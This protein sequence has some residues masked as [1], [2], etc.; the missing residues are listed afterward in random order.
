ML[1]G[2]VLSRLPESYGGAARPVG[3]SAP[4]PRS[5]PCSVT[6][7][8]ASP[9]PSVACALPIRSSFVDVLR[10][11]H[12]PAR[13]GPRLRRGHSQERTP[14]PRPGHPPPN[15]R[16][17]PDR[18][19]AGARQLQRIP[20][21]P[22]RVVSPVGWRA[23]LIRVPLIVAA[24]GESDRLLRGGGGGISRPPATSSRS[25]SPRPTRS[26]CTAGRSGRRSSRTCSAPCAK[27]LTNPSSSRCRR[28]SVAPTRR[29]RFLPRSTRGVTIVNCGNTRRVD[30]PRLSFKT[31]GL[32]GPAL[33]T[34]TLA[35]V[36]R[37]RERFADRVEII[38]TGGIDTPTRSCRC[39]ARGP[40]PART[41]PPSYARPIPRAEN[42][43]APSIRKSNPTGYPLIHR[44][45][46]HEKK[47]ALMRFAGTYS[48]I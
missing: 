41:S 19:G 45:P 46:H 37:L 12:S 9:S 42:F 22:V 29:P 16:S 1:Y 40:R 25:T 14:R 3:T 13:H 23:S 43:D 35:D 8:R 34:E 39:S 26:W 44:H 11:R 21:S 5:F 36:R 6:T 30:E 28:T 7:I 4:P 24:A 2:G 20:Q 10:H 33:F 15:R 48:K 27:P 32:L 38:A 17:H 47:H 31:G 18:Q